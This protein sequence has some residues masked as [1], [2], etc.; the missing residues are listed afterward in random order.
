MGRLID[1]LKHK[2][3]N[4]NRVA[5]PRTISGK[6]VSGETAILHECSFC[7]Y[8]RF[9]GQLGFKGKRKRK[10]EPISRRAGGRFS[11]S[12]RKMAEKM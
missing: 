12:L 6:Y 5:L 8:I 4:C 1:M 7:G 10:A 9:H 2:C 11:T 3:E